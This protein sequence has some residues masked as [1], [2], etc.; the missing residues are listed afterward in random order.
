[1]EWNTEGIL[2]V[3]L[4]SLLYNQFI[5]RLRVLYSLQFQNNL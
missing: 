2:A 4:I 5:F 3:L 1:M